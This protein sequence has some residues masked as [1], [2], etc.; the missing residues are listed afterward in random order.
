MVWN[1][2]VVRIK[3]GNGPGEDVLKFQE[4]HYDEDTG[5]PVGHSDIF[6]IGDTIEEMRELAQRLLKACDHPI[7]DEM[8]WPVQGP[9]PLRAR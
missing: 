9:H 8:A 2:R 3:D 7:M 1:H 6:T 4:V 5:V